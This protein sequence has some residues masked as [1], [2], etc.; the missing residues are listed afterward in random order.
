LR[1]ITH[2]SWGIKTW[3]IFQLAQGT[4]PACWAERVI[5]I[6]DQRRWTVLSSFLEAWARLEKA[7]I[8]EHPLVGKIVENS[9]QR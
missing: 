6:E 7:Q 1:N 2:F 3:W 5:P 8:L 4:H 9:Y